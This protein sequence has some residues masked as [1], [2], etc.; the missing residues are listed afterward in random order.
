VD[1]FDLE[2]ENGMASKNH[3]ELM[4]QLG[5]RLPESEVGAPS[6]ADLVHRF[7]DD[8]D[9]QTFATIVRRHGPMVLGICKR[10]TGSH[11]VAE[12]AFQAVFMVLATKARS[13]RP[14]SVLSG[15]LYGVACRTALRARTMADRRRRREA[16]NT[17]LASAVSQQ[18]DPIES[19]EIVAVLDEEIAN[20]SESLRTAVVLCELQG[21]SRKQAA[22]Q[23]GI[24]EGTISS[25]LAAA[26]KIL[27]GRLRKRG[28]EFSA[29]GSIAAFGHA[30]L[31]NVPSELAA[32]AI[33]AA[34]SPSAVPAQVVLLSNGVIR[35]MFI[36]KL[37][38]VLFV[39]ALV[40]PAVLGGVLIASEPATDSPSVAPRHLVLA[41]PP[42]PTPDEKSKPADPPQPVKDVSKESK[43]GRLMMWKTEMGTNAQ[44]R[45]ATVRKLVFLSPEGKQLADDPATHP[46]NAYLQL[47]TI[48]PDG[49][50]VAFIANEMSKIGEGPQDVNTF[51]RHVFIR[52]LTDKDETSKID[53]TAQNISWAP[54]GKLLVTEVATSKELRNCEF[55]NWVVDVEKKEK[56]RLE[57]PASTQVFAVTP[58]GKSFVAVTYQPAEKTQQLSLID[59]ESK[60]VTPLTD[61]HWRPQP[62]VAMLELAGANP[63]I[64]SD[65][66]RILFQD[67]DLKEELG[68]DKRYFPRLYVYDMTT[69]KRSRLP[70]VPLN[71]QILG[72]SWSP[73]SQK[74]AYVWKRLDPDAPITAKIDR[75]GNVD[76][77]A[78]IETETHV[79]VAQADG[80]KPTTIL[81]VKEK[82]SFDRPILDL[83]WR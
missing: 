15:W 12:D 17:S 2:P 70:E 47:P 76:P 31:A 44:N 73:D 8:R 60:K 16:S 24:A 82:T 9:E 33:V 25:R 74:V 20:L 78:L 75:K 7:L 65:G 46:E 79:I 3:S 68:A 21:R 22:E 40:L 59:R 39:L 80:T 1:R 62:T 18:V 23:L 6:D 51:H 63:K 69:K 27:A 58:D 48:S 72:Y 37:K 71:G 55:T 29:A 43:P 56:T 28:I 13:I 50:R 54:D 81:T 53:I 35:T 34:I 30:G 19:A 77:K 83:D 14:P 41:D 38:R 5:H 57:M 66:N 4:F 36:Q 32:R 45:P 11:H 42:K 52:S 61:V 10:V 64:S 49:K 26:R 67:I